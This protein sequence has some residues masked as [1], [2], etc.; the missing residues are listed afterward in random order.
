[1]SIIMAVGMP[2][3][4]V[5]FSFVQGFSCRDFNVVEV[6]PFILIGVMPAL[7]LPTGSKPGAAIIWIVYLF[8]LNSGIIA[9][10]Y[11]IEPGLGSITFAI[12]IAGSY[13]VL[14]AFCDRVNGEAVRVRGM[15]HP[16]PGLLLVVGGALLMLHATFSIPFEL[17]SISDVYGVRSDYKEAL[18]QSGNALAGYLPLLSGFLFAPISIYLAIHFLERRRLILVTLFGFM[19]FGHA[20]SVYALAAFKS[21]AFAFLVVG[22]LLVLLR[23]RPNPVY[24]LLVIVLIVFVVSAF[25][26]S[27]GLGEMIFYHWVRRIALTP[28]M[29]LVYYYDIIGIWNFDGLAN[30]PLEISQRVYGIAGSANSGVIG[31]G[32][33]RG[34]FLGLLINYLIFFG[35]IVFV[36]IL[37]QSVP[38][39]VSVSMVIPVAYAF[40]NS[41]ATTVLLSYGGFFMAIF[42][43]VL[44]EGERNRVQ[45]GVD[46]SYPRIMRP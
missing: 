28:G 42:L 13:A 20:I 21:V 23:N 25:I 41:A 1:M 39:H 32:L 3:L 36:N 38:R 15:R 24:T 19:A 30:A 14:S 8:H 11:L 37:A 34:G 27:I 26:S 45:A 35:Y 22:A 17:P 18:S 44:G 46:S 6:L 31:D 5:K 16:F 2:L 10:P 12:F 29:N 9:L 4:C 40:S 7:L 43:F 33:A